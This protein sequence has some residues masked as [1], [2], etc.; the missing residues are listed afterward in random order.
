MRIENLLIAADSDHDANLLYAVGMMSPAPLLYFRVRGRSHVITSAAEV[1]RARKAARHCRVA[2]LSALEEKLRRKGIDSSLPNVITL[3][4]REHRLKKIFVPENFPLGLAKSLRETGIKLKVKEGCL[5][6]ERA[7]KSADQAK[8]ISAALTM[9]EVGLSEAIRVLKSSKID[10]RG[11]LFYHQIPLTSEK[12]RAVIDTTVLQAGG[13]PRNTIVAGGDQ[14]CN[15]HEPGHGPLK[16]HQ[17][18]IVDVCPR[19]EKTGY[20]GDLARTVVRGR[21][22]DAIWKLYHAVA[23]AQEIAFSKLANGVCAA[24]SHQAVQDFYAMEGYKTVRKNGRVE[25]SPDHL[26]HGVGLELK[27]FPRLGPASRDVL[28]TGNVVTVAPGL[29]YE[30]LGG[31]RLEDIAYIT[32]T[33]PRNLTKFEKSLEL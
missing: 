33:L 6:P 31:V 11:Q 17:P 3:F 29:Y 15:P 25:G 24:E 27:E 7:L 12:L 21:G 14:S 28:R 2:S 8:K 32:S 1:A 5:F 18:I 23:R 10:K 20:F 22:S 26:G 19:S 9:A 30:G 13:L 16:A 4:L